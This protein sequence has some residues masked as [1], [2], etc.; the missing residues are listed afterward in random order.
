MPGAQRVESVLGRPSAPLTARQHPVQPPPQRAPPV[1]DVVGDVA[2]QVAHGMSDRSGRHQPKGRAGRVDPGEDGWRPVRELVERRD[3]GL[4]GGTVGRPGGQPVSLPRVTQ[5]D[6]TPPTLGVDRH[7]TG[8]G[9][10]M[11]GSATPAPAAHRSRAFPPFR[12]DMPGMIA[13]RP[14]ITQAPLVDHST[15]DIATARRG[16]IR[17]RHLREWVAASFAVTDSATSSVAPR[18]RHTRARTPASGPGSAICGPQSPPTTPRPS[19]SPA[20]I[21]GPVATSPSRRT[22]AE[23][24]GGRPAHRQ[25]GHH[26]VH[27]L[28]A[29]AVER[30]SLTAG[31]RGVRHDPIERRPFTDPLLDGGSA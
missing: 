3:R 11:T 22:A 21:P 19:S 17:Q 7:C 2:G 29:V 10:L 30:R 20:T 25:T 24:P 1:G 6:G 16:L 9:E 12:I 13:P 28:V 27:R 8:R 23:T 4:G 14:P 26:R 31:Q 18:R 15:V 5:R